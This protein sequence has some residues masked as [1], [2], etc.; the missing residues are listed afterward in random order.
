MTC[1]TYLSNYALCRQFLQC[2]YIPLANS[3]P[4]LSG[5][6]ARPSGGPG[7]GWAVGLG[8]LS[9]SDLFSICFLCIEGS[10]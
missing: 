2:V 9:A 1:L 7:E 4:P 10:E 6:C 5:A 3:V 8:P